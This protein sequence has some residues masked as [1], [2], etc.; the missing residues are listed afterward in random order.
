M[1]SRPK[2]AV[3]RRFLSLPDCSS[4]Q[5]AT[6]VAGILGWLLHKILVVEI[7]VGCNESIAQ[8]N[9]HHR[10][11]HQPSKCDTSGVLPAKFVR[12]MKHG[13]QGKTAESNQI[14]PA[15][16]VPC[17]HPAAAP[18]DQLRWHPVRRCYQ[19]GQLPCFSFKCSKIHMPSRYSLQGAVEVHLCRAYMQIRC[20]PKLQTLKTCQRN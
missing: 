9:L 11:R 7:I 2:Y 17:C 18:V 15:C 3:R 1:H 6:I 5:E 12:V 10:G 8:R 14:A 20:S 13:S 16:G 4:T 19:S